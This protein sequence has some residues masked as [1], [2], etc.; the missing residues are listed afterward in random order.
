MT[1]V[2]Y[3]CVEDNG[4]YRCTLTQGHTHI[5]GKN[6]LTPQ[7]ASWKATPSLCNNSLS[8]RDHCR[9]DADH[10]GNCRGSLWDP[11]AH[12]DGTIVHSTTSPA[13]TAKTLPGTCVVEVQ[14]LNRIFKHLAYVNLQRNTLE[15][16]EA[17]RKLLNELAPLIDPKH[18]DK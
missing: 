1:K 10:T 6:H 14:F 4:T 18:S 16:R 11:V 8:N 7:G 17:N 9:R 15:E 3:Q 12:P 2:A 13:K 5:G